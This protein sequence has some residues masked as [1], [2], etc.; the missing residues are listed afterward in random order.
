MENVQIRLPY[1]EELVYEPESFVAK[2]I[3]KVKRTDLSYQFDHD[4]F[5]GSIMVVNSNRGRKE[6]VN[7]SYSFR[8]EYL[9]WKIVG[10]NIFYQ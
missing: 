7:H 6:R 9:E 5:G 2:N 10:M 8:N 1:T 4:G 3:G